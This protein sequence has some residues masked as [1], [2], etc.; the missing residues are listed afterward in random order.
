MSFNA[1]AFSSRVE[2]GYRFVTPG[3][4][5]TPYGA[6]QFTTFDLPAYAEQ[7][8]SGTGTFALNYASKSVT[9]SRSEFGVRTD[10]SWAMTDAILT[11]RGRLAWAHDFN[12]VICKARKSM[13][14]PH[15]KLVT[16]TTEKRTVTPRRRPN[17]EL[18]SREHLTEAEVDQLV[19]AARRNRWGHRD[20]TMILVAWRH[21]L[22]V[23]ELVDLRWDQIDFGSATSLAAGDV[24]G[25]RRFCRF[26]R[27]IAMKPLNAGLARARAQGDGVSAAGR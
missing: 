24:S 27:D 2:G 17:A 16:P 26:D 19:E 13:A 15:L 6:G 5:I 11:L 10:R 3:I 18:R 12:I 7:V 9:A 21:G 8:L 14:K 4:G 22:R 1:N 23:S 25:A 20:S